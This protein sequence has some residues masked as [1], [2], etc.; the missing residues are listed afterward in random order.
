MPP[1]MEAPLLDGR[2]A[3]ISPCG[4]YRYRLWRRWGLG[5]LCVWVMLN[6]SRA[7]AIDDDATI[8]R[9]IGYAKQ[10]GFSGI[11]VVNLFPIIET[12]SKVAMRDPS[13][14]G[15]TYGRSNRHIVISAA[16]DA[17]LVVLAWGAGV[18][19][20]HWLNCLI[21]DIEAAAGW[22]NVRCLGLTKSG[23]PKHPV[24]LPYET[25]LRTLSVIDGRR[26]R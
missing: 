14:S 24:R 22:E 7:N 8:R 10:W 11:E 26:S 16:R 4:R 23:Q 21:D 5:K 25:P 18:Q 17:G 9:C 19:S 20:A 1:S 12:D 3:D 6:P 2:G 15:P 13:R